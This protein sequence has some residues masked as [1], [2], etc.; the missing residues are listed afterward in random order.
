MQVLP[1]IVVLKTQQFHLQDMGFST[2]ESA[3][4]ELQEV[5]VPGLLGVPEDGQELCQSRGLQ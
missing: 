4:H 1:T 2:V 3:Q 5:V